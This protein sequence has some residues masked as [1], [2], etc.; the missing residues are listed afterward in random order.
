MSVYVESNFVLELV[1]QQEQSESCE[2]ILSLAETASITLVLPTYSLLEPHEKLRRQSNARDELQRQVSQELRQL[3]RSKSFRE[4]IAGIKDLDSLL[5]QSNHEEREHLKQLSARLVACARLVPL[6][7]S[8][9]RAARH[10]EDA[11]GL[12]AQDAAVLASVLQD[13]TDFG[14]A[15]CFINRNIRD[16][17]TPDIKRELDKHRCRMI[18]RFDHGLEF[19]QSVLMSEWPSRRL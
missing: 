3:R 5:V 2:K 17:D 16:F 18:P 10:L 7:A 6:T 1:L 19:I 8:L 11:F 12:R 13:L 4:R 15:S 14:E 9:L